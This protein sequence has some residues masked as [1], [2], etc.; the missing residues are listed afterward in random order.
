MFRV[1]ISV[2]TTNGSLSYSGLQNFIVLFMLYIEIDEYIFEDISITR[3]TL[4]NLESRLH[5]L[6]DRGSI[7]MASSSHL[8]GNNNSMQTCSCLKRVPCQ[9]IKELSTIQ[10]GFYLLVVH[11][12]YKDYVYAY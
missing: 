10:P 11:L 3:S 4:Y 5:D 6:Y 12:I 9:T 1:G 2:H 8:E 7:F